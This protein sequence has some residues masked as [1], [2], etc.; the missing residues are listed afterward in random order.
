MMNEEITPIKLSLPEDSN[1]IQLYV[2]C[3]T[4]LGDPCADVKL[5]EEVTNKIKENPNMYVVLLGDILN[6]AIVNSK[7]DI[8]SETLN[9]SQAQELALKYLLPIKDKI[10]A[11][12]P[13][14]HENR[15]WKSVGVDI[16][17]WLAEKLGVEDRYRNNFLALDIA[18]GKDT[19]GSPYHLKVVGQHGGY[20]GGRKLGAAMNAL[21][22]VDGIVCNS[23]I[24]IRAHTHSSV[25]GERDVYE[26][27]D[28]G[29]L[30]KHH[31]TYFNAPAFLKTGGYGLDKGYRPQSTTPKYLNIRA[32]C[33]REGSRL[34]KYFKVDEIMM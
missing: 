4:H 10:L 17:L 18:F 7:S 29:N 8:Y 34:N 13:G 23:D 9:V 14:N 11:M 30:I 32:F 3:D 19:N 15:V 26:F 2:L 12:T 5:L 31:K 6:T 21:E 27:T 24:Y 1:T 20:G 22:D 28:A 16:S 33:K 25:S